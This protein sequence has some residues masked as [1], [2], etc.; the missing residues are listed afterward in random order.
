MKYFIIG[1][2]LMGTA[3]AILIINMLLGPNNFTINILSFS[4]ALISI[5]IILSS[6]SKSESR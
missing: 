4:L 5:W 6:P 3:L 1:L 2:I